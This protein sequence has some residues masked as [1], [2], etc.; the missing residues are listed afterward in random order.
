M[1][2]DLG[3]SES[4]CN[5]LVADMTMISSLNNMSSVTCPKLSRA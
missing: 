5:R 2:T 1:A 3:T 4:F